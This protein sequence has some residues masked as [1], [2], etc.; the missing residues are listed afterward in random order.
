[1]KLMRVTVDKQ[2]ATEWLQKNKINRRLRPSVVNKYAEDIA[3]GRWC[4]EV[5]DPIYFD[6]EGN[7]INGQHRL[8]AIA[9]NDLRVNVWVALGANRETFK[10]LDSG[11]K[12]SAADNVDI[13]DARCCQAI[14]TRILPITD[15]GAGIASSYRGNKSHHT[16]ASRIE[17]QEYMEQHKEDLVYAARRGSRLKSYIGYGWSAVY[18][19]FVALI[20]WLGEDDCLEEFIDDFSQLSDVDEIVLLCKT[21]LMSAKIKG[22]ANPTHVWIL[23]TLLGAYEK[24]RNGIPAKT[25]NKQA[26]YIEDCNVKI[27]KRFEEGAERNGHR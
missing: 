10:Y 3:A 23:A 15:Y 17:I 20:R 4:D 11:E 6:T 25:L 19:T 14:A 12:R 13:P 24:Y 16:T 21:V 5:I 18:G 22:K 1:M 26:R 27:K 9:N 7:L 8:T 2:L